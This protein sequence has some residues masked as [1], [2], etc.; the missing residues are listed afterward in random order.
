MALS[1]EGE[2][3]WGG[4]CSLKLWDGVGEDGCFGA[5]TFGCGDEVGLQVWSEEE[6]ICWWVCEGDWGEWC[7]GVLVVDHIVGTMNLHWLA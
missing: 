2:D 4:S 1:E 3:V 6:V 7:E 5:P